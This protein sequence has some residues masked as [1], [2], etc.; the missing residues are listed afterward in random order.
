MVTLRHAN[1]YDDGFGAHLDN[2]AHAVF[3][4][5]PAPWQAVHHARKALQLGGRIA[6]FSPCI[7]QVQ[8]TVQELRA[9]GFQGAPS[10][11]SVSLARTHHRAPT[12][13][14]LQ[15][16]EHSSAWSAA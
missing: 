4:D 11:P 12:A 5:L 13:R 15:T 16:S 10:H 14:P 1:V 8:R 2:K 6:T 3:L 9:G 7:E